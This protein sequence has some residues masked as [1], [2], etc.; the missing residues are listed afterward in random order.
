MSVPWVSQ[1]YSRNEI[2]K[3]KKE[4]PFLL[5]V[6]TY[7]TLREFISFI[8]TWEFQTGD[9]YIAKLIKNLGSSLSCSQPTK[10]DTG[11]RS[12]VTKGIQLKTQDLANEVKYLSSKVNSSLYRQCDVFCQKRDRFVLP[13]RKNNNVDRK[14]F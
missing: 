14:S 5:N 13:T 11:L 6:P 7:V 12:K 1:L 2:L 10:V 3:G 4:I 8:R 9:K